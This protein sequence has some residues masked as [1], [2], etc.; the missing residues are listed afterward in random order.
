MLPRPQAYPPRSASLRR[1][2]PTKTNLKV[3]RKY[4]WIKDSISFID[5]ML[6]KILCF[7]NSIFISALFIYFEMFYLNFY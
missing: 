2:I 5:L 1:L 4:A 3:R 7:S 6:E